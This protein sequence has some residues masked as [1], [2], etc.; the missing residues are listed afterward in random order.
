MV[1]VLVID[2][3]EPMRRTVARMLRQAG[4][5]VIEAGNGVEGIK[6]FRSDPRELVVTDIIMPDKEGIETI[7]EIRAIAPE[8]RIIAMSGRAVTQQEHYL[9][10][11]EVLGADASLT[12]PFRVEELLST[13][14]RVMGPR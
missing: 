7:R 4:H 11:A 10:V 14:A 1:G 3:D 2:D 9:R 13:L 8:V 5:D 12:K 6:L